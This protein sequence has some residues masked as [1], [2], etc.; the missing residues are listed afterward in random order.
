MICARGF[1]ILTYLSPP[2][3]NV[4]SQRVLKA[5]MAERFHNGLPLEVRINGTLQKP[6][7]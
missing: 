7:E 1:F 2:C 6:L 5:K 4:V 3:E